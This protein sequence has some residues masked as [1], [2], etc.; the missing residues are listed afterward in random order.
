[1]AIVTFSFYSSQGGKFSAVKFNESNVYINNGRS[2]SYWRLIPEAIQCSC[3]SNVET[4]QTFWWQSTV[5][6]KCCLVSQIGKIVYMISI[7]LVSYC[8]LINVHTFLLKQDMFTR[9]NETMSDASLIVQCYRCDL[10]LLQMPCLH[11]LCRQVRCNIMLKE[12]Q[13]VD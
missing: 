5:N 6:S 4:S 12:F 11:L 1:M 13:L 3:I 7:L 9:E 2:L 10:F 8:N